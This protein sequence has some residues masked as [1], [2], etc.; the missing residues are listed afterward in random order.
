M[1]LLETVSV[2]CPYCGES[3]ELVVDCSAGAQNYIE[4]CA[5]CCRP[6][7]VA[8]ELRDDGL[9]DVAVRREDE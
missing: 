6:M 4:D 5:V 1:S 8:I 9:P 7:Q 3:V 2:Q